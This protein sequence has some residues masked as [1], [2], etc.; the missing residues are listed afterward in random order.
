[1][2][3]INI[4]YF[5]FIKRCL[6]R[7]IES[8]HAAKL[9]RQGHSANFHHSPNPWNL[10]LKFFYDTNNDYFVSKLTKKIAYEKIS[11]LCSTLFVDAAGYC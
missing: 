8:I 10:D 5:P 11:A 9:K 7:K 2:Y 1:M 6:S 3:G 4:P